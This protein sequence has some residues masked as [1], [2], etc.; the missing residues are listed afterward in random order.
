[1]DWPKQR[2][3]RMSSAVATGIEASGNKARGDERAGL[4]AMDIVDGLQVRLGVFGF[5]IHDLAANHAVDG[6]GAMRE[7]GD[8]ADARFGRTAQVR[9]HFVGVGLKGVTGKNGHGFA[10][11]FVAGGTSAAKIVVVECGKVVVNQGIGVQHFDGCTE[12][13][14]T[15]RQ[16]CRRSCEPLPCTRWD[17]SR[18]PPAKTRM[19]HG[20]VNRRR[21]LGS[22][23][24]QTL[25]RL[26]CKFLPLFKNVL[27]HKRAV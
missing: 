2:R 20:L 8:D 6:A 10:E 4:R 11:G 14:D 7:F 12:I 3:R 15:I 21:V 27:Q 5:E 23:G 1:M 25:E 19:P 16:E 26:V 24:Q 17:A 22:G 13:V 18:L 9:H